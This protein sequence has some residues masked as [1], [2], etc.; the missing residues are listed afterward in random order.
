MLNFNYIVPPRGLAV[1]E[2]DDFVIGV[3]NKISGSDTDAALIKFKS[4]VGDMEATWKMKDVMLTAATI[5][6][7]NTHVFVGGNQ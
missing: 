4:D 7:G 3:G 2:D 6:S 5:S 1:A